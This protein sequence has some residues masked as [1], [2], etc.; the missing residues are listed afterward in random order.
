MGVWRDSCSA[1]KHL[2]DMGWEL[3]IKFS[4]DLRADLQVD[5]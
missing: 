1:L 4:A 2:P 3:G 5:I